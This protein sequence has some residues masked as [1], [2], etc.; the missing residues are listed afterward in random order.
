MSKLPILSGQQCIK[1]L[2]KAGFYVLRQRGS[3]IILR[4]DE[5]FA[6]V[7]VPNHQE[8][9]KGTLRAIIRQVGL[10]VD[11]FIELL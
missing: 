3:H 8:L 7:V 11:E 2:G 1:T 4:R 10:S 6:E 5:P 9:D